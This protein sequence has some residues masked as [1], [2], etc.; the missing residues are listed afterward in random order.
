MCST[1][2]NNYINFDGNS[3]NEKP[4]QP[5]KKYKTL[6]SHMR[7]SSPLSDC[8]DTTQVENGGITQPILDERQIM[9]IGKQ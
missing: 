1:A 8:D 6:P 2:H 4:Q 7:R 9:Q 3:K 5:Q